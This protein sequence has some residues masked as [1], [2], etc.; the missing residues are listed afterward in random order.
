MMSVTEKRRARIINIVYFA[1]FIAVFYFAFTVFSPLVMP[2]IFAFIVA[3]ILN[4]PIKA[5]TSKT[6][7]KRPMLSVA[8]VFLS[9][10]VVF[11][12]FFLIGIGLYE[13][14]KDF[15]DY[16]MAQLQNTEV[17]FNNIK[18]WIL[19]ITSFLPTGIRSVLH[20][21][22]TVFFDELIETGSS[23]VD[24]NAPN[25]NLGS[26]GIDWGSLLSKSGAVLSGTVGKIPSFVISCVIF[27]ISTVFTLSDYDRIKNFVIGQFSDKNAQR[28][29]DAVSLGSSCL[30]K[31][32][33]AYGL[34]I[35]ITTFELT[36]GLYA[37]KF[38][39]IYDGQYI[40]FIAFGIALIDIIPVLGTGTV[41]IPWAVV[42][43]FV[44]KTSLG[45]GL[46]VVYVIILIIRQII[47]PK[48]V[49]GQVGL[50]PI[51]TIV[52]MYVGSKTLGILGFFV[53]PFA[54]ILV[55]VFNDAGIIHLFKKMPEEDELTADSEKTD[56]IACDVEET[57]GEVN[58]AVG[59]N[60]EKSE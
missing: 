32:F 48:L 34:I 22:V 30:K 49:A 53:L 2:F 27:L 35:L 19:D 33:R 56:D 29:R 60:S 15:F 18:L 3:T 41:L 4:K 57:V 52:A 10:A 23:G 59:E 37:L 20:E 43:F 26:L 1:M 38:L 21:N 55:K 7:L 17:L 58:I 13:K 50:P 31:M 28:I 11:A 16:I 9:V 46:L 44:N 51:V 47:E 6:R 14:L 5:I 39:K 54:V 45:I 8:F 25:I 42:S 24:A 40:I 12:V 36:V